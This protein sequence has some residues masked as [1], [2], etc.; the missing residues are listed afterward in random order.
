MESKLQRFERLKAT[1]LEI[2]DLTRTQNRCVENCNLRRNSMDEINREIANCDEMVSSILANNP[3][4]ASEKKVRRKAPKK[5]GKRG[6]KPKEKE[7]PEIPEEVLQESKDLFELTEQQVEIDDAKVRIKEIESEQKKLKKRI[8][9]KHKVLGNKTCEEYVKFQEKEKEIRIEKKNNNSFK[10][11][12]LALALAIVISIFIS[13]LFYTDEPYDWT[14]DDGEQT[15]KVDLVL[16]GVTNCVDGSDEATSG[17][18]SSMTSAEEAKSRWENEHGW[19]SVCSLFIGIPTLFVILLI[20]I[21][22]NTDE[23]NVKI[24]E[25]ELKAEKDEH[26]DVF[27][28]HKQSVSKLKRLTKDKV[29]AVKD[30]KTRESRKRKFVTLIAKTKIIKQ[31]LLLKYS[32]ERDELSNSLELLE[33]TEL[34]IKEK[35]DSISDLLPNKI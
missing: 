13:L 4:E 19:Y 30:L 29:R 25:D 33:S 3:P 26:A 22:P 21:N 14:C 18:F 8:R 9:T 6:E 35:Y 1:M 34:K 10:A 28:L 23:Q 12:V 16:D 17:W 24:V 31:E 15:I 2:D 32:I 7:E 20:G 11:G 27:T 5:R